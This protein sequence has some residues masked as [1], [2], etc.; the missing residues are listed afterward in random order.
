MN[1]TISRRQ[2]KLYEAR[3]FSLKRWEALI[4]EGNALRREIKAVATE[5]DVDWEELEDEKVEKVRAALKEGEK[6][7]E[8]KKEEIEGQ[9]DD[10]P[11]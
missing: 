11:K 10:E 7:K 4:E 8:R 5:Y 1:F 6:K 9:E 2:S 3:G